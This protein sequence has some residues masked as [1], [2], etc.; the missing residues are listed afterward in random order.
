RSDNDRF[1]SIVMRAD[2]PHL[3]VAERVMA[4]RCDCQ[5]DLVVGDH[6]DAVCRVDPGE[7][8]SDAELAGYGLRYIDFVTLSGLARAGAE[9]RI[10]IAHADADAARAQDPDQAVNARLSAGSGH[11]GPSL[12]EQPL[13]GG[14]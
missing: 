6:R 9:Q 11:C 3:I 1:R 8:D 12:P 14:V 4:H 2:E 13:Q 5:I 10:M 7:L